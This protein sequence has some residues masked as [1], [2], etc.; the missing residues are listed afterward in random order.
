MKIEIVPSPRQ[1]WCGVCKK[2][3]GY[4]C[5]KDSPIEQL[6]KEAREEY[7]RD[8]SM[9]NP[10]FPTGETAR[11]LSFLDQKLTDAYRAGELAGSQKSSCVV[12]S[13]HEEIR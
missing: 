4:D 10:R 7:L 5:P 2:E 8:Y 9:E 1:D 12:E 13:T 6:I 11:I 3:H